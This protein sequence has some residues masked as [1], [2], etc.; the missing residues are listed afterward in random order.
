M[1]LYT[2]LLKQGDEWVICFNGRTPILEDI[3][4]ATSYL[5][6][7]RAHEPLET[8]KLAKVDIQ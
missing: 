4:I 6:I 5:E 7:L 8:Y 1:A 3:Y 2:V